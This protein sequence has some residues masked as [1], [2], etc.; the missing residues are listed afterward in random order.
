MATGKPTIRRYLGGR[1]DSQSRYWGFCMGT[2]Q[3]A[4][5]GLSI[6]HRKRVL[7]LKSEY[8]LAIVQCICMRTLFRTFESD[9]EFLPFPVSKLSAILDQIDHKRIFCTYTA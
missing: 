7:K 1:Y 5:R 9:I 6:D 2:D 3:G 8:G 4:P